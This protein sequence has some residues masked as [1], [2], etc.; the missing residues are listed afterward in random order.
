MTFELFIPVL[1]Q[2]PNKLLK[3]HWSHIHRE[4]SRWIV[5]IGSELS[6]LS[7]P[8][9]PFKK[10]HC[11]F[12]RRSSQQPDFDGLAGSFKYVLD[13][14]VYWGVLVDDNPSV[15]GE[16]TYRWEKAKLKDQGIFIQIEATE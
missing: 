6:K 7:K 10:A 15:I 16:S 8:G 12:V 13:A 9:K 5:L 1:P 14:L 4:K 3:K 2:M 11:T